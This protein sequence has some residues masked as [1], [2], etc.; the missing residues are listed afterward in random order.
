MS[1]ISYTP[2]EPIVA[3]ATPLVPAALGIV[4]VS[5]KSCIDLLARTFSRPAA[6]RAASGNTVVYGWI[7]QGAVRIDEVL[8]S[9]FRAPK[10]FTGE[11]MAEITCHGGPAVIR[12]IYELLCMQGFR[13]A[14]RGEFT[15]RAFLNGKTDLTRAE[16][17]QEIIDSKSTVS[18]ERAAG[19]LAGSVYDEI[20]RIKQVI[21]DTIA[22]IEVEI[23]YPEDEQAIADS[24]DVQGI[25]RVC[26]DLQQLVDSWRSEKLYQ[27]GA[28]L[29][30]CGRTNAG[31]SSIFNQLL[32]EERA[33]VSSVAGTTRDWLESWTSFDGI[34]VR[35]FDTAGI[36]ETTDSVERQGVELTHAL[37]E[38][39]DVLAYIV[40]AAVGM[41]LDDE[42]FLSMTI[43][44]VIV[45]WNKC[46]DEAQQPQLTD[47]Q[48]K[49]IP[50]LGGELLM[51]AKT[52]RGLATFISAVCAALIKENG[53]IHEQPG[54]GSARQKNAVSE[55][56]E[57]V[58]HAVR[59]SHQCTLDAVVQDLED[60]L[61]WLGEVTGSVTS[62]DILDS[63][64]SRFC[65]GK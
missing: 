65:V 44:P 43:R 5:G 46:D 50:Q 12:A 34:P 16:A 53:V 31:K 55:A 54:L 2:D 61:V 20:N 24:F 33:I 13:R 32:K 62:D 7:M 29:V 37:T 38:S 59:E 64:F 18:R 15:F 23:E 60:A 4:R 14:E 8:V 40:D 1:G 10:S 3:I 35:V 19:R 17:V 27:D 63:V 58:R 9:V 47:G 49:L 39:A 48:K 22:A 25:E 52:G 28:Q 30:L 21:I 56:L 11:E 36:R 26:T 45:V 6:L 41:Q 51:S 42:S 57:R